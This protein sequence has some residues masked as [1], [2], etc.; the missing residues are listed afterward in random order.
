ME[1][2]KIPAS[3]ITASSYYDSG[4]SPN[5]ARLN[6][7]SAWASGQHASPPHW[8]QDLGGIMAV[9]MLATQGRRLSNQWVTSYSISS[10]V[11]EIEWVEF[12]E[13]SVVKVSQEYPDN[14]PCEYWIFFNSI[15]N[16]IQTAVTNMTIKRSL[17]NKIH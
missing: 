7:P 4:L 6:S 5:F 14:E 1:N 8:L 16:N 10:S 2:G 13:N 15:R 9:K 3:G 17:E 11:D 12:M